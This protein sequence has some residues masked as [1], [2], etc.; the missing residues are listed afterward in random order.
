M[1][2]KFLSQEDEEDY[3]QEKAIQDWLKTQ[4]RANDKFNYQYINSKGNARNSRVRASF[5]LDQ[6]IK[7]GETGALADFVAGSDGRD[8]YNGEAADA[9]EYLDAYLA[10]LGLDE[11]T[12][13][14]VVKTLKLSVGQSK[15][16]LETFLTD[17]EWEKL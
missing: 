6:K 15:L 3:E 14:W 4:Q 9:G 10:C 13:E 17:L 16:H 12:S 5:S 7:E 2:N 1:G 8:L 11:E